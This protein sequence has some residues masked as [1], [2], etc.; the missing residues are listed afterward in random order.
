MSRKNPARF[1]RRAILGGLGLSA[2]TASLGVPGI[3]SSQTA[4]A[5][6]SP[7]LRFA[8]FNIHHGADS[9][10]ETFDLERIATAIER[11]DA[12]AIGL[13][14]VDRF[15]AR[16]QY[17]DE[18]KWL[19]Q[20]LGMNVV[21]GANHLP[22]PERPGDRD[23]EY[24]TAILTKWPIEEWD[25]IPLP[26][27][28]DHEQRGLLRT[29]LRVHGST[30]NFHNTHLQFDNDLEREAQARAI[31]ELAGA[32]PRRTIMSGDFN[33]TDDSVAH[34]IVSQ[35]FRDSWQLAG[36]GP[37]STYHTA[38]PTVRIDYLWGGRS[39]DLSPVSVEVVDD[40]PLASDHLP[41][42]ASFWV[43]PGHH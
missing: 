1:S 30:V 6:E 22:G 33:T 39:R 20:R 26:R 7:L 13:Q 32:H 8:T 36:D 19:A 28:A 40:D 24:G 12:D 3:S 5:N 17:I 21:F 9:S 10:G 4:S 34:E 2:V 43:K 35:S 23:R 42:V 31:V 15:W 14:E 25:N 29:K 11:L 37:G 38:D 18:P 16:S 41:V 27:F